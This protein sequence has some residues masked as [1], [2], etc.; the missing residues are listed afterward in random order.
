MTQDDEEHMTECY[1]QAQ[2]LFH[3]CTSH[4]VQHTLDSWILEPI[5]QL[6]KDIQSTI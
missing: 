4:S 1:V 5:L 6:M 3:P 2:T